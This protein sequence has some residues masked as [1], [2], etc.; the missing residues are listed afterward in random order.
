MTLS[1][2]SRRFRSARGAALVEFAVALPLLLVLI[3]GIVDF[4]FVFQR[5]E[6]ITNAAREGARLA[7]VAGYPCVNGG[8][9][10]DRVREYLRTGLR[11]ATVADVAAVVPAGNID[12]TCPDLPVALTGGGNTTIPTARVSITYHHGFVM[13]GPIMGLIGSAWGSSINLVSA[14]QMRIEVPAP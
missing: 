5:Y 10:E 7:T 3:A 9:V 2:W 1:A 14:S 8:A 4:G 12:I 13:L 6:V 11:V